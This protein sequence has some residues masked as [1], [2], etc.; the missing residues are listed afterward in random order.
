MSHP[1]RA[2]FNMIEQQI[3]P[4]E[5]FDRRVLDV[6]DKIEREHFV[7][8]PF[9]G[10]AYADCQL[11]VVAGESMLPPTLEGRMLQALRLESADSVLEIGSGCGYITAC[12]ATLADKVLSVDL[13]QEATELA[14]T[15][16]HNLGYLDLA[17]KIRLQTISSLDDI[18]YN[19]RFDA[20]TVCAGSLTAIPEHLKK[21]LVIGGRLFAVTGQ[22]PVKQ[23]QLVTRISQTEWDTLNLFETD[24]P[25]IA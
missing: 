21:A 1:A 2:K 7:P 19:E 5:V 9:K 4:W 25:D 15:N 11:P 13:L 12:L 24:I 18:S 14:S 6:F 23:A 17:K 8:E 20:I 22:S 10:L 16:L 3:R